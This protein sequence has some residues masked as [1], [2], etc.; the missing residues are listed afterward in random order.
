MS[1]H[2]TP[3]TK[4]SSGPSSLHPPSSPPLLHPPPPPPPSPPTDDY[5]QIFNDA[6]LPALAF[7]FLARDYRPTLILALSDCAYGFPVRHRQLF[8]NPAFQKRPELNAP[9]L[10]DMFANTAGSS[11]RIGP[12]IVHITLV[13]FHGSDAAVITASSF[14]NERTRFL[15]SG[16]STP[17]GGE[18]AWGAACENGAETAPDE[19]VREPRRPSILEIGIGEDYPEPDLALVNHILSEAVKAPVTSAWPVVQR[20]CSAVVGETS[21]EDGDALEDDGAVRETK[22]DHVPIVDWRIP[23]DYDPLHFKNLR[24]VDWSETAFGPMGSW[25]PTLR[26]VALAMMDS[27]VPIALYWGKQKSG[28]LPITS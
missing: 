2:E 4:T 11:I 17:G 23:G 5:D 10:H 20:R 14:E 24:R 25:S 3:S 22:P 27:P 8:A 6:D 21:D 26:S 16:S 13:D 19:D 18:G 28:N 9:G 12:W 1:F 7:A 15:G